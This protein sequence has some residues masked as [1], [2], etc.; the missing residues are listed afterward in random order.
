MAYKTVPAQSSCLITCVSGHHPSVELGQ[1]KSLC[2]ATYQG[3]ILVQ[4]IC[5]SIVKDV[6]YVCSTSS[7]KI[8]VKNSIRT[9]GGE[10]ICLCMVLHSFQSFVRSKNIISFILSPLKEVSR[11]IPLHYWFN[12][13][14]CLFPVA[15]FFALHLLMAAVPLPLLRCLNFSSAL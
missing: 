6:T 9:H 4:L 15:V 3:G 11:S 8:S 5:T 13:V 7:W 10:H 12:L 2:P 1:E 14:V